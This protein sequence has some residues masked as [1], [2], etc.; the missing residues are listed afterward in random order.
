MTVLAISAAAPLRRRQAGDAM[1]DDAGIGLDLDEDDG[2]V[3]GPVDAR[4]LDR[5]R[6]IE[7]VSGDARDFHEIP[8][9][10][11]SAMSVA[12]GQFAF[13]FTARTPATSGYNSLVT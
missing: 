7:C 6:R 10:I 11:G 3:D 9:V 2:T 5:H 1:A 8:V 4:R 12:R 13:K